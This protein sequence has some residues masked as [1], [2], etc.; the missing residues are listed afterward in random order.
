MSFVIG[1]FGMS[2]SVGRR[3]NDLTEGSLQVL[4]AELQNLGGDI[5]EIKHLVKNVQQSQSLTSERLTRIEERYTNHAA[6]IDR[7]FGSIKEQETR[8]QRIE[9]EQPLTKVVR[10]Y[11]IMGVIAVCG[12]AGTF[13][14]NAS[15]TKQQVIV[16][17]RDGSTTRIEPPKR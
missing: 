7:A 8:I 10:N 12:L 4:A 14:W 9:V 17:D 13:I 5:A 1:V 3:G 11:A 16:V 6:A 2:E 15:Q